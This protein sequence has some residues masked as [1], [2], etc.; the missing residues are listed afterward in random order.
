MDEIIEKLKQLGL[1]SYE[2]KV[3]L[4]LLKKYPIT[5][6]EVSQLSNVP[7]ARAYDT[8]KTLEAMQ[9][10]T[11][12]NEK[13]VKY[14]PIKP[15]E[16]TKRYRRKIDSALDFLD[17][18]LPNV[19]DNHNEPILHVSG[20][21]PILDKL[22]EAIKNAKREIY[23]EIWAQDFKY[24]ENH[25]LDAYNRGLNVKIVGYGEQ[26]VSNFGAVFLHTGLRVMPSQA[27]QRYLFMT[28]D[29]EE[30]LFGEMFNPKTDDTNFIWTKNL[31]IVN[32]IKAFIAHDMCLIDIEQHFPEQLK[33]FY[34]AG[35]KKLRERVLS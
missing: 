19:K 33:Y 15:K 24:L 7:Q 32:L 35:L 34:G 31:E 12:N 27:G 26:F 5:G 22:I 17:K 23:I 14:T 9:I 13:P 20:Y 11:S 30:G 4:A 10:V 3:Y 18:K 2:A 29:D 16:L 8:L 21:L 25:L 6:Y 1:N 28:I